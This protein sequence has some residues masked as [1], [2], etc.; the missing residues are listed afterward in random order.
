MVDGALMEFIR[1]AVTQ[2]GT[3]TF[4]EVEIPT[5]VSRSEKLAMLIWNI[6][7]FTGV[8]EQ[9]DGAGSSVTAQ[10]TSGSQTAILPWEDDEVLH[11]IAKQANQDAQGTLS[12]F[13]LAWEAGPQM[14][15]FAP[16]RL[17]TKSG[18]FLGINSVGATAVRAAACRVGY[19]LE[20]VPSETFIAA[21][22]E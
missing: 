13:I 7:L 10:L 17:Y 22:V 19:T 2:S 5:P 4:T 3:N 15:Q 18:L 20:R 12:E 14:I 21:L 6:H 1:G 9:L 16:P 11:H 8:P